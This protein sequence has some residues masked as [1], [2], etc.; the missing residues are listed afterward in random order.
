M[1]AVTVPERRYLIPRQ[2]H[3]KTLRELLDIA[4][5][6]EFATIPPYLTAMYSIKDKASSAYQ[7]VRGVALEEMLH[8]NLAANLLNAV[9]G[10]PTL[11]TEAG[12]AHPFPPSYPAYLSED[13]EDGG[14]YLQLMAASPELF[15]STFMR[16]EQPAQPDAVAQE[17]DFS[18]VGQLYSAILKKLEEYDRTPG[19]TY[20]VTRQSEQWNFGNSGGTVV[21]VKDL[22]S[23]KKAVNEIVEQG[24][25]ADMSGELDD[26]KYRVREPWGQYEYYGP[27]ADGTYGPVL[28]TPLEMSH[29]FKFKAIADGTVPLPPTY[30][31]I[32]NPAKAKYENPTAAALSDL[33]DHA[34]SVLVDDLQ[35]ALRGDRD[36]FFTSV[37]PAMRVSL[38]SLAAE[39]MQT[40]IA[41][42][43]HTPDDPTAGPAFRYLPVKDRRK[44]QE[45]DQLVA[46]LATGRR[47]GGSPTLAATLRRIQENRPETRTEADHV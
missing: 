37:V 14:P 32:A 20:D 16:I 18:T 28:G 23:A 30:P 40:P 43:S 27:R 17:E 21:L 25:G 6:V 9:G 39:L 38:P 4:L 24:E 46:D 22:E 11:V 8:L 19:R 35:K 1:T 34:Y 45:L 10:T 13:A 44:P 29:Y 2:P 42:E 3:G 15:R 47:K 12:A 7:F 33:F 31:M 26:P 36:L 5:R 41:A